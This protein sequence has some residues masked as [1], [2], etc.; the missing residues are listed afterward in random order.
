MFDRWPT[1]LRKVFLSFY[2][3]WG[4]FLRN[5]LFLNNM[6]SFSNFTT[7][8]R[9]HFTNLLLGRLDICRLAD[10][11]TDD[12]PANSLSTEICMDDY[13]PSDGH[14]FLRLHHLITRLYALW[15][16]WLVPFAHWSAARLPIGVSPVN[17]LIG[18]NKARPT[19][20]CG[21]GNFTDKRGFNWLAE[22]AL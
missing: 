9:L 8:M 12:R 10:G 20:C 3:R 21:Y 4:L 16:A 5:F 17:R 18:L 2:F 11:P 14:A 7:T 1:S 13:V 22:L 19:D 15:H 6:V